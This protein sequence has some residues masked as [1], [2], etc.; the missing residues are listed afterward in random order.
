MSFVLGNKLKNQYFKVSLLFQLVTFLNR[1]EQTKKQTK[2]FILFLLLNVGGAE[3]K[4]NML[5]GR[6]ASVNV[7]F[8]IARHCIA[9]TTAHHALAALYFSYCP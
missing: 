7:R 4:K 3:Q 2:R 5:V 6:L 1:I 8:D 9:D